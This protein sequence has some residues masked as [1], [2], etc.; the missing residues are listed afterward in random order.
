MSNETAKKVIGDAA[1]KAVEIGIKVGSDK[2][3]DLNRDEIDRM[4]E[5]Y[6]TKKKIPRKRA[7]YKAIRELMEKEGKR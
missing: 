4:T 1:G 2:W 7:Q 6:M 5:E 3:F